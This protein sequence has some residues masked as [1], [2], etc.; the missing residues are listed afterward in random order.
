MNRLQF[1]L[2][3]RM[4]RLDTK[5]RSKFIDQSHGVQGV[6]ECILRGFREALRNTT[7]H[8]CCLVCK[9]CRVGITISSTILNIFRVLWDRKFI[10]Q[11]L[12]YVSS[13]VRLELACRAVSLPLVPI[14]VVSSALSPNMPKFSDAIP[15]LTRTRSRNEGLTNGG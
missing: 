8:R 10:L 11:H 15:E 13:T 4:N 2:N 5:L 3:L 9:A 12:A 6:L 7:R 1:V 14:T